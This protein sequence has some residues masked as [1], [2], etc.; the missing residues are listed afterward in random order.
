MA[1]QTKDQKTKAGRSVKRIRAA[2]H[3][4]LYA[5]NAQVEVSLFEL[6]LSFGEM[7]EADEHHVTFEDKFTVI[8]SPQHAKILAAAFMTNVANYEKQFGK[9][10]IPKEFG[11]IDIKAEGQEVAE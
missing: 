4:S 1:T 8:L 10:N 2:N 6:K 9:I 11:T 3:V 7:V 5:N